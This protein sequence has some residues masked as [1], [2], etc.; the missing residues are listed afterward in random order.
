MDVGLAR[1]YVRNAADRAGASRSRQTDQG[2]A[3]LVLRT[4]NLFAEWLSVVAVLSM[5]WEAGRL[6]HTYM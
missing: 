3:W 5:P 2:I 6:D 4:C 1:G